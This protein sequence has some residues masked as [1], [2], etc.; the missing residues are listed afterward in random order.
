[1]TPEQAQELDTDRPWE[2][3]VPVAEA[4]EPEKLDEYP[5]PDAG[6]APDALETVGCKDPSLLPLARDRAMELFAE[7]FT[8]YTIDEHGEALMCFDDADL[9]A[10]GDRPLAVEKY[11]W[12]KS[13]SF[14]ALVRDSRIESQA[15]REAAFLRYSGDAFAIY[16]VRSDGTDENRY[17]RFTDLDGLQKLGMKPTRDHYD[18]IYT[19]TLSDHPTVNDPEDA[20]RVFN[21][22]R[23]AD[24]GGHSLSVSDIVAFRRDGMVTYHYCDSVGFEEIPNFQPENYLKNAEMAVEDDYNS[25]DGIINNGP[26]DQGP[27][28]TEP[29]AAQEQTERPSLLARL[30]EELPQPEPQD[31]KEDRQRR[32]ERSV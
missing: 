6:I 15:D 7:G 27:P 13:P 4:P 23:P 12:E 26:K 20:F 5:M 17:R 30:R 3:E 21:L 14:R 1:M 19:G 18:L 16:Q 8:V 32:E 29:T 10:D 28:K 24:F 25:I 11:E 31:R 22:E 2:N 9:A